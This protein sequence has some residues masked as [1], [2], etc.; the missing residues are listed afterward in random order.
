MK[1]NCW[2]KPGT[3]EVRYYI[4]TRFGGSPYAGRSL[5]GIM[6]T[7]W[8]QA[9]ERGMTIAMHKGARGAA[10][11]GEDGLDVLAFF[12]AI[13]LPFADFE[14]RFNASLTKG[15]N[16]SESRYFKGDHANWNSDTLSYVHS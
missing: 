1:L 13:N 16:F 14:T 5:N 7:Y 12:G 10:C 3:T 6:G 15:G 2:T 11:R 8:L 9:D 4:D